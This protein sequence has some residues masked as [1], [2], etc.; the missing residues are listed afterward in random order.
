[1]G[2]IADMIL[3][4]LV[5]QVCGELIDGDEPGYPRTCCENDE[6]FVDNDS[7]TDVSGV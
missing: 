2:D 1:M 5:C 3:D 6:D 7:E 4:G